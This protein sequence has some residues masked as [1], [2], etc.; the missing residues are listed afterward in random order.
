MTHAPSHT[1]TYEK[2]YSPHRHVQTQRQT[3]KRAVNEA[4]LSSVMR[5]MLAWQ[6]VY[7]HDH[8]STS[9]VGPD[10]REI[11]GER[12]EEAGTRRWASGMGC[13]SL[14]DRRT[15]VIVPHWEAES[16]TDRQTTEREAYTWR[17]IFWKREDFSSSSS[18]TAED[19]SELNL[20]LKSGG[21]QLDPP[22]SPCPAV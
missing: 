21:K 10:Q 7:T 1:H 22:A 5:P 4:H 6:D 15:V 19:F 3:Y 12:K 16:E 11:R 8:A 2:T 13:F 18:S 9:D 14:F 17:N 20:I